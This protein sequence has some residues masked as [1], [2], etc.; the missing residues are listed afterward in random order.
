MLNKASCFNPFLQIMFFKLL[1]FVV[2][3]WF[4]HIFLQ[5]QLPK[6]V[7]MLQQRSCQHQMERN[8]Y[9]TCLIARMRF[10]FF[11][12]AKLLTFLVCNPQLVVEP[13]VQY[14]C[15][16]IY[17][18]YCILELLWAG[19]VFCFFLRYS[20][21]HFMFFLWFLFVCLIFCLFVW[22]H[23]FLFSYPFFSVLRFEF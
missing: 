3:P 21:L 9:F 16:E 5:V 2:L 19:G 20:T 7:I 4:F 15:R 6:L 12:K 1:I 10:A 18:P 14:F 17:S 23:L 13:F 11:V 22:N 8:N